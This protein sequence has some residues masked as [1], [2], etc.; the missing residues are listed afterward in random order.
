MKRKVKTK[1][2]KKDIGNEFFVYWAGF[3]NTIEV[4]EISADKKSVRVYNINLDS[5]TWIPNEF[6][7]IK[8]TK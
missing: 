8:P 3:Y 4:T 6:S 2:V 1:F 7:F 5:R